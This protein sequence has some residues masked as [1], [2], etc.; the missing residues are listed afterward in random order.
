MY[1]LMIGVLGLVL[2]YLQ[3][4]P[5]A[6]WSWWLVLS[7][8]ALAA[9]WWAWADASGYTK[10]KEIEKMDYRKKKRIDRQRTALGLTSKKRL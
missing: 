7:P 6:G 9:V 3:T 8:F 4:E 5:V 10:R 1:L 2:K